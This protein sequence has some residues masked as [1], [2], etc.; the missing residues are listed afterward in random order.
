MPRD[1]YQTIHEVADRL[2]VNAA[3]VR[4]WVKD[5]HLRAIDIGKGWRISDA[6]LVAFLR[7]HETRPRDG[8]DLSPVEDEMTAPSDRESS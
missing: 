1:R 8:E 5:G 3:T 7:R 4:R 6:D 2:K